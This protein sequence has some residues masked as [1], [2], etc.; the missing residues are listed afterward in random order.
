M[1]QRRYEDD[2]KLMMLVQ[3]TVFTNLTSTQALENLK[4]SGYEISK[5]TYQRIKMRL[6]TFN[7][8]IMIPHSHYDKNIQVARL[9][10]ISK[11]KACLEKIRDNEKDVNVR[12]RAIVQLNKILEDESLYTNRAI[13]TFSPLRL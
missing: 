12:I 4:L 1:P 9:E 7:P 3:H 2:P 5:K 10:T 13:E 6:K 11:N 8:G